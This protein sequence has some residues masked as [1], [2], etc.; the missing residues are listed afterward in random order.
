M[1]SK[2]HWT[3]LIYLL[4]S[5]AFLPLTYFQHQFEVHQ[6]TI[7]RI[8]FSACS[9]LLG[10]PCPYTATNSAHR[11]AFAGFL[12]ACFISYNTFAAYTLKAIAEPYLDRE[13]RTV[14]EILCIDITDQTRFS[15]S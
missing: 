8:V 14:D 12:F 10:I 13:I 4:T 3:W 9:M 5:V 7:I 6:W 2:D 1:I 15:I 11:F